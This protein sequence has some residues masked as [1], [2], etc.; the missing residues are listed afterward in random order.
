MN[1]PPSTWMLLISIVIF[2]MLARS[3]NKQVKVE[4]DEHEDNAI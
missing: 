4:P 1:I 3:S 2:I